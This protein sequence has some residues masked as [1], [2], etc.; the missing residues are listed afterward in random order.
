MHSSGEMDLGTDPNLTAN[1]GSSTIR[2]N[3]DMIRAEMS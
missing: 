3:K 2:K 1:T